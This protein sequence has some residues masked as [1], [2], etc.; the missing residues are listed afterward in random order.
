MQL[1]YLTFPALITM[2]FDRP[3]LL[4]PGEFL[5]MGPCDENHFAFIIIGWGHFSINYFDDKENGVYI[6]F[7]VKLITFHVDHLFY[8]RWIIELGYPFV[9]SYFITS[10][11]Y[12]LMG[13]L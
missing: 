7:V 3:M 8:I 2:D 10:V 12:P 9:M 11:F 6:P 13:R 5:W 4:P 1:Y